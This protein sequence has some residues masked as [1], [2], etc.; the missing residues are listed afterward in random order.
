MKV[1]HALSRVALAIAVFFWGWF[2]RPRS[3]GARCERRRYT[4]RY[5]DPSRRR[6][7]RMPPFR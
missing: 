2:A 3:T 7:G 4:G 6:R 5:L 1:R